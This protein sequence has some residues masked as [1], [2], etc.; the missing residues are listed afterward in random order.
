MSEY[1]RSSA[2]FKN[3]AISLGILVGI[4]L[5][6]AFVV[7]TR[8]GEHIPTVDYRPDA[9]VLG[10]AADYPVRAPSAELTDEGWTPTSST[11][12]VSGPVEWS[13]G[14]A[15]AADSHAM[16]TQSDADPEQ[17]VAER[18]KEAEQVG[19]VA[20]GG[21][22]WEHYDSEDWGAL[23]LREEGVTLVVSGSA[24]LDEL[25]HL[26]EGLEDLPAAEGDG[27]AEPSESPEG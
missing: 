20:V 11:L 17:V 8:S 5:I 26:A 13:V 16:F 27:D 4:V 19:T 7:S 1:S 9:D 21:R 3:Y 14:F 23:V 12:N 24:E 2:T 10:E 22:E 15:T 18:V 25:A 6:M